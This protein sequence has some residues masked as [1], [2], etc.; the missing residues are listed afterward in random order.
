MRTIFADVDTGVDD[1][2]ALTYLLGS[3]DAEVVG[4]AATGGNVGLQQV[5]RNTLAVLELCGAVDIPVAAGAAA[6]LHGSVRTA[7][8]IHGPQG[9]GYAELAPPGG[10][11]TDY[12]AATAWV[13]AARAHPGRLVGLVTGPLTNLALALR[14]EPALPT[15]LHRLVIMGGAFEGERARRAEFN[16]GVDPEA[17]AAVFGGWAAA[18]PQRPPIV[19]GLDVTRQVAM[20][21]ELLEHLVATVGPASRLIEVLS[22]ALRFYFEAHADAGHG[23]LAYLHDPLAAAVAVDPGLVVTRPAAVRVEVTGPGR[24][25]TIPDWDAPDPGVLVG[26]RVDPAVVLDRL[27]ERIG[28]LARRLG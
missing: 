8:N 7:E 18:A 16:I 20:T 11:L 17:A 23:Y 6:P 14:A 26:V 15:L 12:D 1:A 10:R 4:V 2:I 5:C 27:V 3:P 25:R 21:P 22:D 13:R 24:G 19:C 9:L 28:G